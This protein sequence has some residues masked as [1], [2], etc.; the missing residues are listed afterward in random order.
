MLTHLRWM[1]L[2]AGFLNNRRGRLRLSTA[3]AYLLPVRERR[4]LAIR[5]HC[6]VNRVLVADDR[7]GQSAPGAGALERDRE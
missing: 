5:P 6:L 4:N 1:T 3:M 7:A 2:G